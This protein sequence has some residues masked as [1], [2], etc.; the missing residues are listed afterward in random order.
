M[1]RRAVGFFRNDIEMASIDFRRGDK[2]IIDAPRLFDRR[3]VCLA[4]G[5][6][7]LRLEKSASTKRPFGN[8]SVSVKQ[9]LFPS[10]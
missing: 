6:A 1:S 2:R 8:E 10:L 9:K 4:G 3:T 5:Y 7:A